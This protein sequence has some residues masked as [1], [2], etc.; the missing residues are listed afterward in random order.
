M[1]QLFAQFYSMGRKFIVPMQVI[2]EQLKWDLL[3]VLNRMEVS[4][5]RVRNQTKIFQYYRAIIGG[6]SLE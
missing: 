1:V 3:Q 4:Q 6:Q 5:E 2:P